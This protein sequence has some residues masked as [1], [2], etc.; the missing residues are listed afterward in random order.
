[1][2]Y[3]LVLIEWEESHGLGELGVLEHCDPYV[4]VCKSVGWLIHDD[5][6]CKVIVPY[7]TASKRAKEQGCGD[8][9]I[10]AACVLRVIELKEPT[11]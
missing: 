7:L 2:G 9:T 6:K 10:P 1:M 5:D 4:L 8:M 11:G 3:P